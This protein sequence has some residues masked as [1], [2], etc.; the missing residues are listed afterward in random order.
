MFCFRRMCRLPSVISKTPEAIAVSTP[1]ISCDL[2]TCW[3]EIR[4]SRPERGKIGMNK[5]HFHLVMGFH[6]VISRK[7]VSLYTRLGHK[8][9]KASCFILHLPS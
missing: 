5:E 4:W 2:Y 1:Q 3:E 6:L 8:C 7:D 9:T